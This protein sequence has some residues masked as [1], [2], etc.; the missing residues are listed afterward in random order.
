MG[1]PCFLVRSRSRPFPGAELPAA[2]A[3]GRTSCIRQMRRSSRANGL[4][5]SE[6]AWL[7]CSTAMRGHGWQTLH[8]IAALAL[9]ACAGDARTSDSDGDGVP[10]HTELRG[11]PGQPLLDF[12]TYGANPDVPDVFVQADWLACDPIVE[13][14]GPNNSLDQHRLSSKAAAEIASYYE[15]DVA[16][17]IDNG[18][19]APEPALATVHG[20][21]GGAHRVQR[22]SEPCGPG[23]LGPR[24][25]SFHRGT[26]TSLG[27][28]GQGTLGG[29]CFATDSVRSGVAA[30]E[31]GHNFGIGHGGNEASYP[32]NCKPNYRSPMN[33]TYTFDPDVTKF[34]RGERSD[35][36]LNP[37]AMDEQLGLGT[38]D[39]VVLGDLGGGAWGYQVREDGAV[40]WNRDGRI[41]TEPVRAAP[42]WAWASCEQ[43]TPHSSFFAPA[44]EPTLAWLPEPDSPRL[45]LLARR[46]DDGVPIYRVATRFDDCEIFNE[47]EPCT[48]WSPPGNEPAVPVPD[49]LGGA[50]AVAAVG[51]ETAAGARMLLVYAD[52]DD[53]LHSQELIFEDGA[54]RWDPPRRIEGA[55][56]GGQPALVLLPDNERLLLLV[57]E[58]GL[59][60]RWEHVIADGTWSGP[61]DEAWDDG[62]P[63][64][65]CHGAALT[66]GFER[67]A[68]G[69]SD[70]QVYAAVPAGD[71]CALELARRGPDGAWVR[72]TEQA[73][74]GYTV[75]L[76]GGRPG[77]A[78]VPFDPL[79][80][81]EGR[82]YMAW[83][84]FP[85][86][87]ALIAFTEGNDL[88][89]D[90]PDRRLRFWPG[91]FLRNLWAIVADGITL[92]FD[93]RFDDNLRATWNYLYGGV[94]FQP[95]ADGIIDV[96][97]RDQDDYAYILDNLACSLTRSCTP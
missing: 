37:T 5:P 30:H 14:C 20:A 45:Y 50:G 72:L 23:S 40:D 73:W 75:P 2:G 27:G 25:G 56:A 41:A 63:I 74:S 31:L 42:T 34:S 77:L 79:V 90:A 57:P 28:G 69:S 54:E 47:A 66:R 13:Y 68:E 3:P 46:A 58:G 94:Q 76:A 61:F 85:A 86:G 51:W 53:Q 1:R 60:R 18:V 15:P 96:E 70:Q 84:P 12:P 59:L 48:D 19:A 17:H 88:S 62:T 24:Y 22:G 7:V 83:R 33:Y 91:T 36:V 49:G 65:P 64:L 43:S 71:I 44:H 10:D 82:F 4:N 95:F 26:F 52:A 97:M 32:A 78:Y 80:P 16:V 8:P 87:A 9:L 29:Y 55:R 89:P 6:V 93:P 35:I 92:A 39:P 81:D 11:V 21:W 67:T 38:G